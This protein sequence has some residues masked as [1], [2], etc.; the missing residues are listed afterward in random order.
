[1]AP[2]TRV[3]GLLGGG[4]ECLIG[5]VSDA[6]RKEYM[7]WTSWLY[8]EADF[9]AW[10][11]IFPSTTGVFPWEPQASDWFRDWQPLLAD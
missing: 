6:R 2:G 1:M 7:G 4:F 3:T 10:Q 9:R 8:K 5:E 11:I